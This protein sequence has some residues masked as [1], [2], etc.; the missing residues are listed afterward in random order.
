MAAILRPLG[1]WLALVAILVAIM[2]AWP[3]LSPW[4]RSSLA[5]G[6]GIL[7]VGSVVWQIVVHLLPGS[8]NETRMA[9]AQAVSVLTTWVGWGLFA[10]GF[11]RLLADLGTPGAAATPAP[12]AAGTGSPRVPGRRMA[13]LSLA[14]F[15][16]A[17]VV[18]GLA[19][20][21]AILSL[22]PGGFLFTVDDATAIAAGIVA[23]L[24]E[25]LALA[26]AVTGLVAVRARRYVLWWVIPVL[27]VQLGLLV[28]VAAGMMG[29][30]A[31]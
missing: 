5:A 17:V 8:Y 9:V 6:I 2:R 10:L 27:L 29:G 7:L 22:R 23:L 26:S 11:W 28:A 19:I 16:A 3:R 30:L 12:T 4:A 20:G 31:G 18:G 1:Y 13:M 15:V 14:L 24:A 25:A 21:L